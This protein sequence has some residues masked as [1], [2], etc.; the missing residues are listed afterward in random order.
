MNARWFRIDGKLTSSEPQA[1]M[2]AWKRTQAS[3]W[4]DV[5]AYAPLELDAWLKGIGLSDAAREYCLSAGDSSHVVPHED[6]IYFRFPVH[7]GGAESPLTD[8][9]FLCLDRLVV[10]LHREPIAL[11]ESFATELTAGRGARQETTSGLVATLLLALSRECTH[12]AASL[13]ESIN[14]LDDRMDRATQTLR[15]LE[16]ASASLGRGLR[17]SRSRAAISMPGVQ[18]PHCAAPWR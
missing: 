2:D 1:A 6:A 17:S 13:R 3:F 16:S 9:G 8:L 4:A 18:M 5:D 11:L 7:R 15:N 14:A 10:T 12:M